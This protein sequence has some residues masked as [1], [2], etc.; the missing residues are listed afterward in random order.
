MVTFECHR[1]WVS[2]KTNDD[3][4]GLTPGGFGEAACCHV[5]GNSCR[6]HNRIVPW[7]R[8]LFQH[9]PRNW[10]TYARHLITQDLIAIMTVAQW[11]VLS[12]L[13]GWR[14]TG[15][16]HSGLA[17]LRQRQPSANVS[18]FNYLLKIRRSDK[19]GYKTTRRFDDVKMLPALVVITSR[20]MVSTASFPHFV[21][22]FPSGSRPRD[23]LPRQNCVVASVLMT[24]QQDDDLTTQSQRRELR[25][26]QVRLHR[27]TEWKINGKQ[28]K[29]L[30]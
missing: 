7:R 8:L 3:L 28:R 17:S 13:L 27:G 22:R 10:R 1:D 16:Q 23:D 25:S 21:A 11:R 9:C 26:W 6:I 2:V 4:C 20:H 18:H 19:P 5:R 30:M 24:R 12:R 14:S 15:H 29:T